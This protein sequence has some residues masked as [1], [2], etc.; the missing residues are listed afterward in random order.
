MNRYQVRHRVLSKSCKVTSNLLNH[1][2]FCS[3]NCFPVNLVREKKLVSPHPQQSSGLNMRRLICCYPI[4]I[5]LLFHVIDPTKLITTL[6]DVK[7]YANPK[8]LNASFEIV[9]LNQNHEDYFVT[10]EEN[11]VRDVG[12][13]FVI[14]SHNSCQTNCEPFFF[15]TVLSGIGRSYKERNNVEASVSLLL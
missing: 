4:L 7:L 12:N 2:F 9:Y 6:D 14:D 13:V 3:I 1:L 11:F 10:F 5:S 15:F 8:Y